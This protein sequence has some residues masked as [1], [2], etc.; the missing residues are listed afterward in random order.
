MAI[1]GIGTDIVEIARFAGQGQTNERLAQRVLTPTELEDFRA[2]NYGERFLAKRFAVK[3]AAVKAAGTGI[4][5][6]ISFQHIEVKHHESGQP[7]LVFSGQL[8]QLLSQNGVTSSHVSLAD[9]Q[10]YAVATVILEK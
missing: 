9:E 1:V 10:H 4:G 2:S 6:G 7:F 5:K 8:Q 3:E